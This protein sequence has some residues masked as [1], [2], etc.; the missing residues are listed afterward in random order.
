MYHFHVEPFTMGTEKEMALKPLEESAE[1]FGAWQALIKPAING[2][3]ADNRQRRDNVIYECCDVI[4]ATANLLSMLGAEQ[5]DID[6][7]M[8]KVHASNE[9]R[10]RY[11]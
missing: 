11:L 3:R 1:A 9:V 7:A 10:G 8:E 6:D 5:Q 4:Q 2:N